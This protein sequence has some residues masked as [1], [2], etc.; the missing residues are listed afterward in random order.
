MTQI[1]R[2]R[3]EERAS[4]RRA[5]RAAADLIVEQIAAE[6]SDD[7]RAAFWDE[8]AAEL[9]ER[10]ADLSQPRSNSAAAASA[11]MTDAEA[12]A[13]EAEAV[14]FGK[15]KGVAVRDAPLRYLDW[16]VGTRDDPADFVNRCR[17]YLARPEVAAE[18]REEVGE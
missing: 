4:A 3:L 6:G 12:R 17:R 14:P 8:V 10:G 15:H 7:W 18:L 1:G 2:E 13:L 11:P 5:A 16:L 9:R